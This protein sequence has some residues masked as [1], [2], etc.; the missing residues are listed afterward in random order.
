MDTK[1]K[2]CKKQKANNNVESFSEAKYIRELKQCQINFDGRLFVVS[3][4]CLDRE[5]EVEVY[6]EWLE[7]QV[8]DEDMKAV[9]FEMKLL[10]LIW[11]T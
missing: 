2:E 4:D 7:D 11:F 9:Y 1:V 10:V 8:G 6:L 5:M 3:R